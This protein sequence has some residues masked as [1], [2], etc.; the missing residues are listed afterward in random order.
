MVAGVEEGRSVVGVAHVDSVVVDE[1][2]D[3]PV[4]RI[5]GGTFLWQG[6]QVEGV[7][8]VVGGVCQE[9]SFSEVPFEVLASVSPVLRR[10][11]D[12]A[13]SLV[14]GSTCAGLGGVAQHL[15]PWGPGGVC[16]CGVAAVRV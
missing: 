7:L 14:S 10:L 16:V 11:V 2:V 4:A 15:E 9:E 3:G 6:V 12:T 8:A 5:V 1:V 13:V